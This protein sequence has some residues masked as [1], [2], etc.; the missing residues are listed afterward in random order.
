M[1]V[2]TPERRFLGRMDTSQPRNKVPVL[3][4]GEEEWRNISEPQTQSHTITL[5]GNFMADRKH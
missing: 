1:N 2:P 3:G 5:S 4:G